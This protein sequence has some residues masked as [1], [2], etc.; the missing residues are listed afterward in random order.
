MCKLSLMT[1]QHV[2]NQCKLIFS[3]Y[4]WLET[5]ISDNEPYYTV[6][7]FTSVIMHI[8]SI[9]LQT[10]LTTHNLMDLLKSIYRL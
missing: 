7:T 4:G 3:E 5:F 9:I 2:V 10:H 1:G 6:D 8:M